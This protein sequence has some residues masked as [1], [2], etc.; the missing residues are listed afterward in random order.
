MSFST[1]LSQQICEEGARSAKGAGGA[2]ADSGAS[3]FEC[4]DDMV[5]SESCDDLCVMV[6]VHDLLVARTLH[7]NCRTA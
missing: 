1:P 2:R 7:L 5:A 6:V 4:V 3:H